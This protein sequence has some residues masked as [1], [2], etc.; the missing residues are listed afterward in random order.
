MRDPVLSAS[1]LIAFAGAVEHQGLK[2]EWFSAHIHP[3][4]VRVRAARV[5]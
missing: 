5:D 4:R 3:R 1:G 2:E